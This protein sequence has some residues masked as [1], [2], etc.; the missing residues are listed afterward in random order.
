MSTEE[1]GLKFEIFL[2]EVNKDKLNLLRNVEYHRS[3]FTYRQ[4]DLTYDRIT[5]KR[6]QK[7]IVEAKYSSNGPIRNEF[8][9]TKEKNGEIIPIEDLVTE[10]EE[11]R[12]FCKADIAILVTN[13]VF[14]SYVL[15]KSKKYGIYL[16]EG[17][18]KFDKQISEIDLDKYTTHKNIIYLS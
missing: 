8:R 5:S 1:K 12:M 6:L 13:N 3:R 16:V 2:Q 11:R 4:A 14:D 9:S 7:V 15:E 17:K 18:K 10:T